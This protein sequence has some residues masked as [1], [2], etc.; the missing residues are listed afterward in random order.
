MSERLPLRRAV[1]GFAVTAFLCAAAPAVASASGVVSSFTATPTSTQAGGDPSI[2]TD[3]SFSYSTSGDSVESG[4][5]VL[6]PGL[7]AAPSAVPSAD[8][9]TTTE[10]TARAC[11][12]SGLIGTGTATTTPSHTVTFAVYLMAPPST[13]DVAGVGVITTIDGT[14]MFSSTG[15]FDVI[16]NAD[17]GNVPLGEL[18]LSN[19]PNTYQV[20]TLD[21]TINGTTE[22]SVPF[23]RMPTSCAAGTEAVSIGTYDS[24]TGTDT[25]TITPTGCSSLGFSPSIGGYAVKDSGDSGATVVTGVTQP[26]G[27][28]AIKSTTLSVPSSVLSP[29]TSAIALANTSTPVGTAT[30][31]TPLLSTPLTGNVY[32]IG[33]FPSLSLQIRFPS[34]T[35]FDLTGAV[36]ITNNSV[37]FAAIPDVPLSA[38]GV[39]LSGGPDAVFVT[40]CGASSATISGAFTGQNGLTHT[41][42]SSFAISGCSSSTPPPTVGKPT[43]SGSFSGLPSGHPKL[44]VSVKHG[45]NAPDISKVSIGLPSGLKFS[46]K[47][48]HKSHGKVTV[49]GLSISGGKLKSAKVSGGKLVITLSKAVSSVSITVKGPLVTET[50]AL[51]KKVKKHKVKKLPVGLTATNASGTATS[52]SLK[53]TA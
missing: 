17:T 36:N 9:C 49:K 16:S 37:A 47:A 6:P 7:L 19:I 21:L 31:V 27:Q 8:L 1:L 24:E 11:P 38:L 50:K 33:T 3:L 51:A 53:L 23:T 42:S 22:A 35:A 29:N 48:I 15:T 14:P 44:T 52:L 26:V 41:A 45:S 10:L 32:L 28:A 20:N 25:A 46:G 40:T 5:I 13:A 43:A 4:T 39:T 18:T 34:P 12:A 2:T 30:A